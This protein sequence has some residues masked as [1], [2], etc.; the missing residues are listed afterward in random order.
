MWGKTSIHGAYCPWG[1]VYKPLKTTQLVRQQTWTKCSMAA[2]RHM[3]NGV[4]NFVDWLDFNTLHTDCSVNGL[5]NWCHLIN[6]LKYEKCKI[7]SQINQT[8][9]FCNSLMEQTWYKF[10]WFFY[11]V[12]NV[13]TTVWFCIR[14]ILRLISN[15]CL[16]HTHQPT[17]IHWHWIFNV[18]QVQN[19]TEHQ[20]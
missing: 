13:A 2:N 6:F 19:R 4:Q 5:Q 14:V 17:V 10:T 18:Q 1:E 7:Y 16:Y 3:P 11:Y 15:G 20:K 8:T 12:S 9:S